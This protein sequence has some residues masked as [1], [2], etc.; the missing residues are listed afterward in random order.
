ML[1]L[2]RY[3]LP[4]RYFVAAWAVALFLAISTALRIGLA[5]YE[6][7]TADGP[8][9]ILPVLLVGFV[10]DLAAATFVII[11]FVVVALVLPNNG[12][13]RKVNGVLASLMIVELLF[14]L[15]FMSIAEVLFWNEFNSRFN[16]IAV[17]YLIYTRETVG[18]IVESYPVGL[19]MAA[20]IAT[21]AIVFLAIRRPVWRAATADGGSWRRR[22]VAAIGLLA[23]APLSLLTIGDGPRDLLA[24]NTAQELASNGGYEFCRAFRSNDLDYHRFYSTID[25]DE[26]G[27]EMRHEFAE[28]KSTSVFVN[29][30]NP[31]ERKVLAKGPRLAV[32]VVLV[33]MESFGAELT[34]SLG[35]RKGLSPNLDRLGREGLMFTKMY[36][37]GTRTVRGL[38][39][40]SLS[41]PPT[42]GQAVVK[43][44]YNKGFQTLGGVLKQFGYDPIYF[45]GG[46]S[47]FDNMADFFGG[48]G[49][50]V[51][52]RSSVDKKNITHETIW[53]IAD[54]DLFKRVIDEM[55]ARHAAGHRVFAHVMT[56][57]NHRPFTYPSGR[58]SIPSG[59]SRDGA[60][61][62][63]DWA[64]GDFISKAS[65]HAWF[66][67]TI[68]VFVADH[69]SV[70]RGRT[71]LPMENYHIPMIIY[72][73]AHIKP[74]VVDS[75]ASQ[76]DVGPTLLALLNVEYD[77]TF[78]GQD[79]LTEGQNHGRA[80]LSNYLAVG[81]VENDVLVELH[82]KRIE[83]IVDL[84]TGQQLAPK[85]ERAGDAVE[86]TIA[87]YQL[88][89]DFLKAHERGWRARQKALK[90]SGRSGDLP[91]ING[92]NTNQP[93]K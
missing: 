1:Q 41:I 82:P 28:A 69:T 63:S 5:G 47:Y 53:G 32:N 51:I 33:T 13:G 65:T 75:V 42:P 8:A 59:T 89:S 78:F 84:K 46:Y 56:T 58:V 57:S 30:A 21:T 70:G 26:A 66:K 90:A 15:L 83:R 61:S 36:A 81:H 4:G 52:D 79:I 86:E 3:A 14:G 20:L 43:R 92:A 31:I 54:E 71:D 85:S 87:H 91:L 25:P 68:F 67:D 77:S 9:N 64:I 6:F 60:A 35:G 50:E 24:S 16:F 23:L 22:A 38:E 55:D 48:N 93:S 72:S 29:G 37:T 34:E 62:Y 17:D 74:G 44:K 40:V 10:Y 73:P 19:L 18:N 49:Y 88:A 80:L 7:W 12:W 2:A 39:A 27:R 11:P 76:I 45:Y